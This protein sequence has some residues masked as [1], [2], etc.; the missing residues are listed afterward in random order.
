MKKWLVRIFGV[1]MRDGP[2][3]ALITRNPVI[4]AKERIKYLQ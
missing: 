2:V 3:K 1:F 4:P